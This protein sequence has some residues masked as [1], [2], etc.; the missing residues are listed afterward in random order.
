MIRINEEDIIG[1]AMFDLFSYK[2]IR[3][4]DNKKINQYKEAVFETLREMNVSF[5]DSSSREEWN[6]FKYYND[7]FN[8]EE[9]KEGYNVRMKSFVGMDEISKYR[10]YIPIDL[11]IAFCNE[12]TKSVLG[13]KKEDKKEVNKEKKLPKRANLDKVIDKVLNNSRY[14]YEEIANNLSLEE[15]ELIK[16]ELEGKSCNSCRNNNCIEKEQSKD[17]YCNEW[18]NKEIIGKS[19]VLSK[20][21]VTKLQ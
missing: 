12:R 2:G 17:G 9:T 3:E 10:A 21:S 1:N 20:K 11:A 6:N 19:K 16:S 14:F 13:I 8:V 15:C 18:E 4:V 5:M 7:C